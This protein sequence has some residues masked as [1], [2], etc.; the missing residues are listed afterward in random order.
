MSRFSH[1]SPPLDSVRQ[2]PPSPETVETMLVAVT[3]ATGH[4]GAN[5]CRTLL[6]RGYGTRA[7]VRRSGPA[8]EGLPIECVEG[9]VRD[10]VSLE[11]LVRGVDAVIHLAGRISIDGDPDGMVWRTNVEG[12][13]NVAAACLS[14]GVRRLVHMSSFHAFRQEP[15]DEPLT[16]HRDRVGGD[17]WP[18]DRSKAAGELE[19]ERAVTQ[20]LEVVILNPTAILGPHDYGPS[21]LGRALLD[22]IRGRTPALVPGGSDWVDVRDVAEAAVAALDRGGAGERY[23]LGGRWTTLAT[24]ARLVE[25]A[26]GRPAPRLQVPGWIARAGV[27]LERWRARARGRPPLYTRQSL[28]A[29]ARSSRDVRHDKAARELGFRPRPLEETVRDTCAWFAERGGPASEVRSGAGP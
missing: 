18:Y 21:L 4:V 2:D 1:A 26:S 13:R 16:E 10:P 15:I 29:L 22:M 11:G 9:D 27:P 6:A 19:L 20:G 14:A 25:E 7:L 8:L 3:G 17:A 12:P 23:L 5:V 28:H 24:L